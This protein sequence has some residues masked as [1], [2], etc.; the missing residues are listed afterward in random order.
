[1]FANPGVR[2]S[3]SFIT[4]PDYHGA[5]IVSAMTGTPLHRLRPGPRTI[6]GVDRVT[7]NKEPLERYREALES[8]VDAL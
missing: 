1:M 8:F 3:K 2:P 4:V 7:I 6:A 5:C